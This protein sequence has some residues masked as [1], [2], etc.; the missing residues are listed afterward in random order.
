MTSASPG[1]IGSGPRVGGDLLRFELGLGNVDGLECGEHV[2]IHGWI[3]D[4]RFQHAPGLRV[5]QRCS[6]TTSSMSRLARKSATWRAATRNCWPWRCC[7]AAQLDTCQL[8]L[9][10]GS[11]GETGVVFGDAAHPALPDKRVGHTGIE[12]VITGRELRSF[13]LGI[14]ERVRPV[15]EVVELDP[16]ARVEFGRALV[17]RGQ[18]EHAEVLVVRDAPLRRFSANL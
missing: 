6:R 13:R 12:R 8:D 10:F 4:E 9:P 18:R 3:G 14:Q 2:G 7:W 15:L 17:R 5:P 1:P 16:A 11:T